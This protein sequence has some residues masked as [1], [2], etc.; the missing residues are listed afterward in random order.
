MKKTTF[1]IPKEHYANTDGTSLMW[2]GFIMSFDDTG[3]PDEGHDYVASEIN[4]ARA[5]CN[6]CIAAHDAYIKA[7]RERLLRSYEWAD[8]NG[9][10]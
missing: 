3:E 7:R 2:C 1:H 9:V 10:E 6:E 8:K 5:N 4:A